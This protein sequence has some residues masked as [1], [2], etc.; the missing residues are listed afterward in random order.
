[1]SASGFNSGVDKPLISPVER[2]QRLEEH[3]G[4]ICA[5]ISAGQAGMNNPPTNY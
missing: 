4:R 2:D 5:A 3:S 1:M